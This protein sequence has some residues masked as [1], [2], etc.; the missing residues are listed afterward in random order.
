MEP[1]K[2]IP[3]YSQKVNWAGEDSGFPNAEEVE[4][5]QSNCCG[6]ACAR[7]VIDFFTGRRVGYWELLQQGLQRKAY[8]DIGWIHQGLVD[9]TAQY[10]V[11]GRAFRGRDLAD[12]VEAVDRESLCIASVSAGFRGGLKKAGTEEVFGKGGHLVVAFRNSSG[13]LSCHHP[14]SIDEWNKED[15][16]VSEEAWRRSFSGGFMEFSGRPEPDA[17]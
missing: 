4:K 5:W 3:F 14:S 17:G 7:M 13:R 11:R 1:R 6:I 2:A 12:L 10:G 8:N 16:V 9:L 15:W